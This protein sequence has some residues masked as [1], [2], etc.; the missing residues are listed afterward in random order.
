MFEFDFSDELRETL[1]KLRKKDGKMFKRVHKKIEEIANCD[2]QSI[3][4]YKNLQHELKE[5]KRVHIGHFVLVFRVFPEKKF[6]LFTR[7]A[8]HDKAYE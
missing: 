7:F 5:R 4:H 3:D 1:H 8:H 2:L 6:V